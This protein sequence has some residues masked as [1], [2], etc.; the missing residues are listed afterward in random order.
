MLLINAFKPI[1]STVK[2][3]VNFKQIE[4]FRL[5]FSISICGNDMTFY[6]KKTAKV[7]LRVYASLAKV[8][9][10]HGFFC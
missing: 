10:G 9:H 3:S 6:T 5:S 7:N 2:D 8:S 1:Q 4:A